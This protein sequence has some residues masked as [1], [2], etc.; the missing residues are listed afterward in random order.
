ML[1]SIVT[2]PTEN[3]KGTRHILEYSNPNGLLTDRKISE[4]LRRLPLNDG[5]RLTLQT[6][7]R[8]DFLLEGERKGFV[9]ASNASL[10]AETGKTARTVRLHLSKLK[11]LGIVR[12]DRHNPRKLFIS[13]KALFRKARMEEVSRFA[14]PP[15]TLCLG[16]GSE[17]SPRR[18]DQRHC[19]ATCRKRA[20]RARERQNRLMRKSVT[21]QTKKRD[22]TFPRSQQAS[23][24]GGGNPL[25]GGE[26]IHFPPARISYRRNPSS[27]QGFLARPSGL[28]KEDFKD[29]E[30]DNN[31]V[32]KLVTV[33]EGELK[34]P[35][36]RWLCRRLDQLKRLLRSFAPD[37]VLRA[38]RQADLQYS[39]ERKIR[40]PYGLIYVMCRD[41]DDAL[42]REREERERR[43]REREERVRRLRE[44]QELGCRR[45]G[46]WQVD[47]DG[48]CEE[49][50]P[51]SD[52]KIEGGGA[53][54]RSAA[55][56]GAA[57]DS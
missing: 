46:W 37:R 20:Q 24:R 33:V 28:N 2:N 14:P 9:Y 23:Q 25:P 47:L 55:G 17:F 40:N 38:L 52:G 6:L 54:A 10:A 21:P 27:N 30:D 35:K 18:P 48:Y 29:K 51:R 19:N 3:G 12:R 50:R 34:H 44:L 1:N 5:E 57:G 36:L 32:Q 16:C 39:A 15:V 43:L 11:R 45:C 4:A 42:L 49:C 8:R 13:Y 41:L 31:V 22:T 56:V 26:E 53:W 7:I